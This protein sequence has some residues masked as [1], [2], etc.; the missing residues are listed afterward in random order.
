MTSRT[1]PFNREFARAVRRPCASLFPVLAPTG[2]LLPF[3]RH[4]HAHR[5][6]G[7]RRVVSRR[8]PPPTRTPAGLSQARDQARFLA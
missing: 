8:L 6:E 2:V 4:S 5:R 7:L 3:T 1:A